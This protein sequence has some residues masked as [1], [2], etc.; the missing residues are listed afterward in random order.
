MP[1]DPVPDDEVLNAMIPKISTSHIDFPNKPFPAG[2][3]WDQIHVS[4]E[5]SE[6][7]ATAALKAIQAA[8]F[9]VV[10]ADA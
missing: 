8:G 4:L 6:L 10:K 9:K 1:I 7:Y 2:G 5:Q 3:Q